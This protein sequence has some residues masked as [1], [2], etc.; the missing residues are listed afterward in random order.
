MEVTIRRLRNAPRF[1]LIKILYQYDAH[2]EATLTAAP[3]VVAVVAGVK[4]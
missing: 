1:P 3:V 4:G 2:Q